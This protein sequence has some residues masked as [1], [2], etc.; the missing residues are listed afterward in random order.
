MESFA[1]LRT[2]EKD[3]D[4]TVRR[5]LSAMNRLGCNAHLRD[6]RGSS[7]LL[8]TRYVAPASLSRKSVCF[9]LSTR[10]EPKAGP[11]A[12]QPRLQTR[13]R[14]AGEGPMMSVY[15]EELQSKRSRTDN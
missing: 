12:L 15:P 3:I 10:S 8:K 9:P 1:S 14:G 6:A 4:E 13:G 7:V 2:F 11:E 5:H